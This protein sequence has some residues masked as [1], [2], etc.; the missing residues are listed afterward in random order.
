MQISHD[1]RRFSIVRLNAEL[2]P[3]SPLEAKLWREHGLQPL[4]VEANTPAAILEHAAECDALCVV[5]AALPREVIDGLSRCRVISRLGTGTD[6]VDV[7]AATE[8]GILVTNVP[9]FCIEEQ[10]DHTMALLLALARKLPQMGK[11]LAAG[12]YREARESARTNQRLESRTL[13]LVGFG[14]SAKAVATRAAGFGMR[15]LA[16][17]RHPE[18]SQ[19]DLTR[20]GVTLVDFDTVLVESD[21][22]SLHL[23]LND[24]THHLLDATTLRRMKPGA[25]LINTAR[26]AIVDELALVELL[27]E[28]RIAGA[29]LDTFEH[30]DPFVEEET[31]PDHPLLSL[32]N[33][34]LTPH[35]AAFSVQ[36]MED[37]RRGSAENALAV[38]RGRWPDRENLVNP[39]VI[40]K[41]ALVD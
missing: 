12:A 36:A 18:R 17:R 32:D 24:E 15:V 2:F 16:T 28:G 21:Y 30:I 7:A 9:Y 37:N 41:F 23:P 29:G 31:P 26:G 20:L 34:V 22:V 25:C 10:A 8:R 13:G 38:L 19:D 33:V 5:S 1:F 3:I 14:N 4:A 11:A 39:S 40:P 27:R 35:V 6:K